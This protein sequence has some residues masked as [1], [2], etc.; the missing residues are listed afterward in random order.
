MTISLMAQHQIRN[1]L[2]VFFSAIAF[3][4][5]LSAFFLFNYGPSGKYTLRN[6][7][8]SPDLLKDL[9]YD[10]LNPK[11]GGI[12]RFVYDKIEFI[13]YN[14]STKQKQST[15]ISPD[16]YKAFYQHIIADTSMP[17]VSDDIIALFDQSAAS[18]VV[19]T[20]TENPSAWQETVKTFQDVNIAYQG[21]YYRI[22]LNETPSNIWVYFHH[23][24]IYQL[25]LQELNP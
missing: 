6:T 9:S 21:D 1:L 16:K 22:E 13:H 5:I 4:G 7:L 10:D 18:L 15:A 11:T 12:S 8:L 19:K 3:A 24:K 2:L 25:A 17:E 20:R 23:P 14:E